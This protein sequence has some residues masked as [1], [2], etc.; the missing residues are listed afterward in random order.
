MDLDADP[1]VVVDAVVVVVAPVDARRGRPAFHTSARYLSVCARYERI[2]PSASR[3]AAQSVQF[4]IEPSGATI[5]IGRM[6]PS[7]QVMS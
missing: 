1:D 5:V 4:T 2:N 6:T 7:F 3:I